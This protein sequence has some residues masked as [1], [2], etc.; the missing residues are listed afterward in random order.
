MNLFRRAVATMQLSESAPKER[1]T[2]RTRTLV[3]FKGGRRSFAEA[4]GWDHLNLILPYIT[5]LC[6]HRRV[7]SGVKDDLS[8]TRVRL[9]SKKQ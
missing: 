2:L 1:N 3:K 6:R 8:S 7:A 9:I 4:K 5:S